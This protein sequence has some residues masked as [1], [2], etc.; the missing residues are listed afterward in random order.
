[1]LW[2]IDF[3]NEKVK[4]SVKEWPEGVL[5]KFIWI[6]AAIEKFGPVDVGMPHVKV[7]GGGLFEIRAKACEGIGRAIFCMM[8]GKVIIILNS[9]IKKT[10]KISSCEIVLA[11]KRMAE[12]KKN[13]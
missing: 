3:Y 7:L 4:A 9:F 11:K 6:V 1:M 2:K 5:A 13:G 10:Q 8:R 12:V